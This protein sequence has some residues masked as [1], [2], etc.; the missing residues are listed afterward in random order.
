MPRD[1]KYRASPR[2]KKQSAPAWLWMLVGL[3]LGAFVMGLAWLKLSAPEPEQK[4]VGAEPDRPP[5]A[6]EPRRP[7]AELPPHK[8]R[9]EFYDKLG[10]QEVLVPD[11]QLDLRPGGEADDPTARYVIQVGSFAKPADAERVKAELALLGIETRVAEATLDAGTVRYRVLA[12]PFLGRT[13]L[14]RVRAMLK[15]NG[16]A[17]LLIKVVK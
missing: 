5:Q 10:R 12:G 8:P 1:Y 3:V 15:Q 6:V 13:A 11:E 16:Y 4:W 9:F 2:K 7:E 14:D 17:Q